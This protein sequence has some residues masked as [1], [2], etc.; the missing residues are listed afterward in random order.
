VAH[1]AVPVKPAPV[2]P[3]PAAT[4]VLIRDRAGGGIECLLM[5]RHQK[6]K[7]A[8]GAFVFP[9][10]KI[11]TDDNPE[12]A[13]AW[14]RGLDMATAAGRL[15]LEGAPR[16]ALGYWIGANS[17]PRLFTREQSL[18]FSKKHL[19][20]TKDFYERHGGKTIIIARFM[21]IVRTYAPFVAG[22]GRMPYLRYLAFCV[23]GALLWVGSMC[24][25]GYFFGNIPA[26][27]K[28]LTV[29]IIVIVLIS[30]SPALFAYAKAKLSS[31]RAAR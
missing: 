29:V 22:V 8:A 27:K 4:L 3:A 10:G 25:L 11:E 9:G 30:I 14:C 12:D 17:G 28:N 23:T 1:Y 20:R 31:A 16:T 26:V 18:F 15:N 21:P 19:L 5:Q 2:T 24:A 13:A 6:S 7:F